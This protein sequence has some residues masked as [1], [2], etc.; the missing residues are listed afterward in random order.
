[1]TDKIKKN[2]Y[3][4]LRPF[5]IH[6]NNL[7]F[8][9]DKQIEDLL[10]Q[11]FETRFLAVVGSSGCGKSSLIRAGLIPHLY[12]GFLVEDRD[13]WKTI[14]DNNSS[15]VMNPG[16][17]PLYNF[18][19]AVNNAVLENPD[20]AKHENFYESIKKS[21]IIAVLE[22]L[23]YF[24]H[25]NESNIL[26]LVDQFEEIFRFTDYDQSNKDS[27]EI[28]NREDA[29]D[30]VSI[31]LSL[32]K[33]KEL[34]VFTVMTMRSDFIGDCDKFYMLPEVMN[35]SQYLVPRMTRQQRKQAVTG[36]ALMAGTQISQVLIQR[37]LNDS[38]EN[39][40]QL[41]VLQHALMRT[42]NLWS[43]TNDEVLDIKHYQSI[44]TLEFALSN[45][46]DEIYLSLN[47]EDKITACKMFKALTDKSSQGRGI[48]RP[49]VLIE[50]CKISCPFDDNK[51]CRQSCT[52]YKKLINI[53]N[54]FRKP[55][56]SFLTPSHTVEINENT[57]IDI[58]HES[59][60][61]VW[62][63][64]NEWVKQEEDS[65]RRYKRLAESA[66]LYADGQAEFLSETELK[67]AEDWRKDNK[68]NKTW[69]MRYNPDFD[70][71]IDFIDK[72]IENQEQRK[73]KQKKA[74]NQKRIFV[75]SIF[76]M[77]ILS[78]LFVFT[79]IQNKQ[80]QK[81][82]DEA[83]AQKEIAIKRYEEKLKLQNSLYEME[84]N[85][86]RLYIHVKPNDAKIIIHGLKDEYFPGIKLN[87][88]EYK[89]II[90][91]PDYEEKFISV[92]IIPKQENSYKEK[93]KPLPGKIIVNGTPENANI[94]L[95]N[96]N[97]GK[98]PVELNNIAPGNYIIKF[99]K[100]EY[101]HDETKI[102][103]GPNKTETINYRLV[104]YAKLFIEIEPADSKI[105][106]LN[107]KPVYEPGMLLLPDKYHI[108]ISKESFKTYDEW[109]D[110]LEGE[111]KKL[112]IKLEQVI[113]ET[114]QKFFK[115]KYLPKQFTNE[116]GMTFV[117]IKAGTFL[118]GSPA[119]ELERDSDERQHQVK[120]TKDYY[121]QTTEITQGQWQ[122]VM[123]S[124]PS[125]FK[126]CGNNCPVESVSW[127]DL[128]EFIKNINNKKSSYIYRLPTEAEWEYAARAGTKTPFAFGNC[129]ST[130]D[131]NY[132]GYP[133]KNCPKGK[134]RG[135]TIPVGTLKS[136]NWGL[137]DMH[138]NVYEWCQDW[139]GSYSTSTITIEDP[140]GAVDGSYRLLRGG[141]WDDYARGCRSAVRNGGTPDS[142]GES[143]GAR[144]AASSVQ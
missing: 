107:I 33:E 18:A 76:V 36:P 24:V 31:I 127:L 75:I 112:N 143:Y 65:S 62:R 66:Q 1:M 32:A 44:G 64:L 141:S 126:K 119:D 108:E 26:I 97:I 3:V 131:A 40:D 51:K 43:Q 21:G 114:K 84:K 101:T 81:A 132:G 11:L 103:L 47:D 9:R 68:P 10:Q 88:G 77:I 16:N 22:R 139:Y 37:L 74:K 129:L 14:F 99:E 63:R 49:T 104:K 83:L 95:N 85:Q 39:P 111:E 120:L 23:L 142:R 41:P 27:N 53:I 110:I 50:L 137:F 54:L 140:I 57:I 48:R 138:G 28:K 123:G 56:C 2:P 78:G 12:A 69:A 25:K 92:N 7:F 136:N 19:K 61:R 91:H 73:I 115:S 52:D 100:D 45:H 34:P 4:G 128:Q 38:S 80:L 94:F 121:I 106:I 125:S 144:L 6:E 124:N 116:Y 15:I 134:Y 87:K 102:T 5:E 93:L 117:L 35:K 79:M 105:R 42:W 30:F 118:M 133:Y 20:N 72:S 130:D 59:L 86:G 135:Q 67:I 122:A 70:I 71:T 109:I 13:E 89:V 29:F 17:S 55:D 113:K 90:N 60:M 98:S 82:K 58:S 8:G 96:K 46:A